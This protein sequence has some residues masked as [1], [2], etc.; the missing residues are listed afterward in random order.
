MIDVSTLFPRL[1]NVNWESASWKYP[2]EDSWRTL[3][4]D[5]RD[6]FTN[7]ALPLV[8]YARNNPVI[9]Y[10]VYAWLSMIDILAPG[11]PCMPTQRE[12]CAALEAL[13][14][15]QILAAIEAYDYARDHVRATCARSHQRAACA[16]KE[17]P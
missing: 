14:W 5:Y 15:P 7:Y 1:G 16:H 17:S 3:Q 2:S 13:G 10:N 11:W 4:Q 9:L 8:N 6:V 12:A